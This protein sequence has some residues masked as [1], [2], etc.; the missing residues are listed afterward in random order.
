MKRLTE[1]EFISLRKGEYRLKGKADGVAYL[2][3]RIDS[4]QKVKVQSCELTAIPLMAPC[5][6]EWY[7]L[8]P[9][10]MGISRSAGFEY[11]APNELRELGEKEKRPV[12]IFLRAD[13]EGTLSPFDDENIP[14][15]SFKMVKPRIYTIHF[16]KPEPPKD[17]SLDD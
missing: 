11:L 10:L 14:G 17:D 2:G 13:C 5:S 9:G 4:R 16:K 15:W 6:E 8:N 12:R 3:A 7:E 1:E